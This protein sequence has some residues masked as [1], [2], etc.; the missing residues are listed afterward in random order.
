MVKTPSSDPVASPRPRSR[1]WRIGR[2]LL[3]GVVL[4]PLL[5]WLGVSI[6][7][8]STLA[9]EAPFVTVLGL[10]GGGMFGSFSCVLGGCE[11]ELI[12]G[13]TIAT[14]DERLSEGTLVS[15]DIDERGRVLV[16][17][18]HRRDAGTEDNRRRDWLDADLAARTLEDRLSYSRDAIARGAIEGAD[19]FTRESDRLVAIE[20]TDDDGV[21]DRRAVLGSW[22]EELTGLIAGVESREGTIWVANIPSIYQVHD[23]DGDGVAE[24]ERELAR[25]FGIKTSL[26]GHDLH[27]FAWGPDGKLYVSIGDRGYHV[28]L[29]N[30]DVLESPLGP[31]RGAVFRM[32]PDGSALEVFATGL[33]NP[34]ELAFDDFGN[35]FTGDNNGDGGDPA[36]LVYVVEG[37]DTGWAMP[38]QSLADGY[39][40]GPW[41]AE[42]LFD[43][44]HATQPAW[45]LPP[46]AQIANG[47]SGLVHYPGLGLPLRYAN[48]FFLCDYAY[49]YGESGIWSFAVE[50][51]GAGFEMVDQHPFIWSVLTPDFDFSWDGRMF[52]ALYDQFGDS[53]GIAVFEHPESR[54]DPRVRELSEIVASKM[55]TRRVDELV[56]WL[57]FPDQRL[58]LRA[59]FELARRREIAPLSALA[60]DA[61]ADLIPRLH[62][63]WALGQIGE[64]GLRGLELEADAWLEDSP[65]ELRAQLARAAG[66][67]RAREW[68]PALR[69][70]LVD[71]SLRVRFFAAQSLGLL[72]DPA[73]VEP[74]VALLREN[75]DGDVFLRHAAVLALH[76]IGA[77]DALAALAGDGSR[78]VRLA[79]LLV[80]RQAGDAR[81]VAFLEDSDPL[82]VVEAARAIYDGP[83]EGA[84]PA[85]ASLAL[86]PGGLEPVALGD[87]QIGEALHRRVIGAN[88]R[89]RTREGV[90]ALARYVADER[91]QESLRTLALEQL[92]SY[93]E[94]PV[95]DLT[96]GFHRPLAPTDRS[97]VASVL[98]SEGRALVES[99]LGARALEIAGA[100]GVSPLTDGELIARVTS[101]EAGE[102]VRLAALSALRSRIDSGA[103]KG[104]KSKSGTMPDAP[105][106]ADLRA[107]AEKGVADASPAI[108]MAARDLLHAVDPEAG[109]ESYFVALES[110]KDPAEQR[111][112]WRRVGAID[113]DRARDVITQGLVYW[114][115]GELD[116]DVAL[117][118]I[119][120]GLV[121]PDPALADRARALLATSAERPVESRRWALA[122]GDPVAGRAVFQT[123]GDCQRC[124]GDPEA[125]LETPGHGGGIGPS[126]A[127][128]A[129][130]G[131]HFALESV[132]E[133]G[134]QIA[135]GFAS[136]SGM[137][138]VGRVLEPKA[139]RDLVAYLM[140]LEGLD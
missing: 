33:R 18:S 34:Q 40:R 69:A 92:G 79:A 80:L 61:Q 3:L 130:K 42:R 16:A 20:D 70:A 24:E 81:I 78:A 120:A 121:Q 2:W 56:T 49:I 32:N 21:A 114:E 27:G 59:Q 76:R 115:M 89:L 132:L 71:P 84:M 57:A 127:G 137:P 103:G 43:L 83:I 82:L 140:S 10:V 109:L 123:V 90:V 9:R 133:P 47:P 112:A 111:H 94:P 85:L 55:S 122:G 62:S 37:G 119:E 98:E 22:N 136:P 96:M 19:Y 95:R 65:E 138:P 51:R 38:Y 28:T 15:L 105:L 45:I 14:F 31:G 29:P 139:L 4:A 58:R 116:D 68:L 48:H 128:I 104:G 87:R 26:G 101:L 86:R 5:V 88:V 30:G 91:Q 129:A 77:H 72:S 125:A 64:E 12:D 73:S 108:R 50:P 117:D 131:P 99:S 13:M 39:V 66:E 100:Y 134:A 8:K 106:G 7:V 63:I 52:A 36:R 25:G 102:P 135:A 35:L 11:A 74:L 126:L 124:H 60:K 107:V 54:A 97:L 44:E 75:D 41:M 17:E 113:D 53:R 110:G 118:V 67:A 6:V 46:I 93:A 23:E 1:A